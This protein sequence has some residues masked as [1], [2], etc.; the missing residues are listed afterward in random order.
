[1]SEI[2][3]FPDTVE[4]F[5]E[6]Y[7]ITD[8]E[9]AYTNGTE[10]V[11]IF[12]MKQWFE[13]LQAITQERNNKRFLKLSVRDINGKPYYSIVYLEIDDNGVG[14]DFE[15]YSSFDLETISRYLNKY[16]IK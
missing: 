3:M 7:K 6:Q 11:P 15:G 4:E 16:F 12:R 13:H 1:M 10:M 5:M 9:H 8:T 2:M 14:H